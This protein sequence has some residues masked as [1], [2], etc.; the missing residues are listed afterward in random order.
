MVERAASHTCATLNAVPHRFHIV[1]A[2][3]DPGCDDRQFLVSATKSARAPG[4]QRS[5]LVV[6]AEKSRGRQRSG[7]QRVLQRKLRQ[8]DRIAH[9]RGHIEVRARER[10]L[11]RGQPSVGQLDRSADQFE[12][13][14]RC[15][16]RRH[17]IGDKGNPVGAFRRK[18]GADRNRIDMDSVDDETGRQPVLRQRRADDPRCARTQR[19][20]GIE[21]MGDAGRAIRDGL[22]DDGGGRLAV[23]DRNSHTRRGQASGQSPPERIRAPA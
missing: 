6:Q 10:A 17:G 19:R 11:F 21:Q 23:A 20:H 12:T 16:D 5:A 4:D 1:G 9:R 18:R 8:P 15:A 13:V 7:A 2:A 14:Q 22:H 3:V